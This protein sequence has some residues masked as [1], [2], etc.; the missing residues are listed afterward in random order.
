[1]STFD[2]DLIAYDL[3]VSN[4]GPFSQGLV[5]PPSTSGPLAGTNLAVKDIFDIEGY[6]TRLGSAARNRATPAASDA[7]VVARLRRAG[8]RFTGKTAMHELALGVTGLNLFQ[9]TPI[10]PIDADRVP[11][12]S[13]SGSAVA[14]ARGVVHA[15]LGSDTGG[16]SRIPAAFCGVVGFKPSRG[17][18]STVGLFP[19]SATLDHVGLLAR[20]VGVLMRIWSVLIGHQHASRR[21]RDTTLMIDIDAM[22]RAEP[23]ISSA[24]EAR[25]RECEAPMRELPLGFGDEVIE[26]SSTILLYEAA[27]VHAS[28]MQSSDATLLGTDVTKSVEDGK[29]HYHG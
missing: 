13:S 26:V 11:G 3:Q 25:L 4:G 18:I 19:L 1:M 28:L 22:S 21:W 16:S 15:A 5:E 17:S 20:N 27:R 2:V 29:S 12:G 23:A 10:N 8:A 6:P 24:V 9:G 14:V 7:D